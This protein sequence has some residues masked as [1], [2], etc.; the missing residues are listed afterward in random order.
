MRKISE[1]EARKQAAEYCR[2]VATMVSDNPKEIDAME[3]GLGK[4]FRGHPQALCIAAMADALS[5]IFAEVTIE[6]R[7][8]MILGFADMVLQMAA[9][10]TVPMGHA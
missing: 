2:R 3:R 6:D 9:I 4:L 8:V 5:H 7:S 10:R 1:D